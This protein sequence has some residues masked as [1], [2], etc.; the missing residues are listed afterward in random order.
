K[1]DEQQEEILQNIYSKMANSYRNCR[2]YTKW[3]KV[4]D[5]VGKPEHRLSQALCEVEHGLLLSLIQQC[6]RNTKD[7][8]EQN[9]RQHITLIYRLDDVLRNDIDNVILPSFRR[10][11]RQA[12]EHALRHLYSCAVHYSYHLSLKLFL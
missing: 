5:D 10:H 11:I 9:Y 1:C 2:T 12:I 3:R 8:A 6:K 7:H 4:H